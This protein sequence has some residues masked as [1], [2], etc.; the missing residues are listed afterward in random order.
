MTGLIKLNT[1]NSYDSALSTGLNSLA[2]GSSALSGAI[3]NG[4]D[5]YP[6]MDFSVIL[7]SLTPGTGGYLEVHICMLMDD[8]S[9]YEDLSSSTRVGVITLA[10]GT[11]A[12]YGAVK[13]IPLPPGDFKIGLLNNA[14]VSLGS[15]GNTVK[16][17]RYSINGN[18]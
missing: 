17:R 6:Y 1:P 5:L 16:T 4:T 3:A 15:S 8:G 9:N 13:G 7:A 14:G 2:N 10:S 11:A 18:G 12:K